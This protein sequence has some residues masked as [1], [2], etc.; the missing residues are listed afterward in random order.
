MLSFF[1]RGVLDEILN[2]I[3]PVSEGF[4]S[5]SWTVASPKMKICNR[6][7]VRKL[8]LQGKS[9]G[10][11]NIPAELVQAGGETII[12]VL[13]EMSE[14]LENRKMA[15]PMDSVADYYTP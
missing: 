15:Y 1:P 2:L 7:S 9:Y 14:D 13:T 5:Y 4:P 3:Q 11:D 12:H 6:S 10:V 8:R